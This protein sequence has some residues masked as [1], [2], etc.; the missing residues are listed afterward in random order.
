MGCFGSLIE[1]LSLV[2][3]LER[4]LKK[5][6]NMKLYTLLTTALFVSSSLLVIFIFQIFNNRIEKNM[7]LQMGWLGLNFLPHLT[8]LL[9]CRNAQIQSNRLLINSLFVLFYTSI[10]LF[11]FCQDIIYIFTGA[12]LKDQFLYSFWFFLP[13]Q[14]TWMVLFFKSVDKN[15]II[16]P[17][18]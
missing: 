8:L 9:Y 2:V 10:I 3:Y 12:S 16:E 1:N 18:Q 6:I 4:V 11:V 15:K 7:T 17:P 14:I 5:I 13:L